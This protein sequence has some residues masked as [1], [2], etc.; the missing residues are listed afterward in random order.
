VL[1]VVDYELNSIRDLV[2]LRIVIRYRHVVVERLNKLGQVLLL[3]TERCELE[4][5]TGII[6]PHII[7]FGDTFVAPINEPPVLMAW[8]PA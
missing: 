4:E 8:I 1:V 6:N 5:I 2:R 7:Q 3:S